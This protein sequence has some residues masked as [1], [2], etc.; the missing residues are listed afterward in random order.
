[1]SYNKKLNIAYIVE[2]FPIIS[3]TFIINQITD[4]IDRGHYVS[5]Y[6]LG[7][8]SPPYHQTVIDY[9]LDEKAHYCKRPASKIGKIKLIFCQM[10]SSWNI[11]CQVLQCILF[12]I[13]KIQFIFNTICMAKELKDTDFDI[14]HAHFGINGVIITELKNQ[15]L[16]KNAKLVTTFHGYDLHKPLLFE[17]CYSKLFKT[18]DLFTVNSE[19][20]KKLLLE[21]GCPSEKIEKLPVGLNISYFVPDESKKNNSVINILFVGRLIPFKAPDLVVTICS[22]L[23]QRNICFACKIVGDGELFDSL[24]QQ[25]NTLGLSGIVE[26]VG[27]QTQQQIVR[28][29]NESDI[30]LFP[31]IYDK[32]GRAENQ[33]LVIQE[34]QYMKLP[35]LVS[36][37]GGMPDG[38]IDGVTGYVINENDIYGFVNKIEFLIQNPDIRFKM[39]NAAHSFVGNEYSNTYLGSKLENMYYKL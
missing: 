39:G 4:M 17:N 13:G 1:M 38:L 19:Y 6:S 12:R 15:G 9:K 16:L 5:I 35:V 33:G 20:S 23:A 37:V 34:A 11:F 21:L 10:F 3:Q 7:K 29:M 24:L 2:S 30:F 25:I 26:L 28:I 27:S 18:G 8:V 31:G 14:I 36:D 22:E 32:T